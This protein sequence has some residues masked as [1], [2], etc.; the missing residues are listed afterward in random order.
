M[1]SVDRALQLAPILRFGGPLTG[2]EAA[3]RLGLAAS[4]ACR[5][6][7]QLR[8]DDLAA[9]ISASDSPSV[10]EEAE[11][12]G[13]AGVA[14]ATLKRQLAAIR[15]SGYGVNH[16]ENSPGIC[17][18]GVAIPTAEQPLEAFTVVLPAA[19]FHCDELDGHIEALV[20]AAEHTGD[21]ISELT[22]SLWVSCRSRPAPLGPKA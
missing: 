18:L 5:L 15:R 2:T 22:R 3:A 21:L 9:V 19:R 16:E 1:E 20:E 4:T 13:V 17:G 14:L 11:A 12:N 7:A 6:L 8:S 10:A